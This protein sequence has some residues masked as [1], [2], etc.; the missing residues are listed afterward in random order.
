MLHKFTL[1]ISGLAEVKPEIADALYEATGGDIEFGVCNGRG[2]ID[3]EREAPSLRD[4]VFGAIRNVQRAGLG[5]H[6]ERVESDVVTT[7]SQI[8][9]ELAKAG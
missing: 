5:L 3:F 2:Y 6:I 4:A 9:T 8:N 7:I 1:V